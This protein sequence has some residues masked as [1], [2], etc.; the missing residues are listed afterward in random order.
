MFSIGS[1]N[2][3]FIFWG[4]NYNIDIVEGPNCYSTF[5]FQK[6]NSNH[7]PTT[8]GPKT[9]KKP[10]II[11][12]PS[13]I[14]AKLSFERFS[15][16]E[17]A[18]PRPLV[19]ILIALFSIISLGESS[20]DTNIVFSPC[21]DASVQRSDGFTFGIVFAAR[22]AFFLNSSVQLSP[23]DRRLSLSSAGSQVAVFRPKVDEISLL[24][25][26]TSNFFPVLLLF[27]YY[28]LRWL[29]DGVML[30]APNIAVFFVVV[31]FF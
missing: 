20:S 31:V 22:T 7:S 25:I 11:I 12:K 5:N 1:A 18:I 8:V 3:T 30:C 19:A 27:L 26:N 9:L 23:C 6:W 29:I 24:T 14:T 16:P 21:A 4:T 10:K 15:T 28:I 17:M 2:C 13:K